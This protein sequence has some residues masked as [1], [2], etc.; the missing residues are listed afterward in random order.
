MSINPEIVSIACKVKP[1]QATLVPEKRKELTTEGGLDVV[2]NYKEIKKVILKLQKNKIPVSLF[3]DP[4]KKQIDAA[5]KIGVTRI[6]LHTGKFAN[7]KTEDEQSIYLE[8]LKLSADYAKEIGLHVFA[9]HGLDYHN[10]TKITS[11]SVIEELN[12]GYSIICRAVFVGLTQAVR[13]MK[14]LIN[15]IHSGSVFYSGSVLR[16]GSG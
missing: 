4:D 9:G 5:K 8:E 13:E 15:L 16:S 2:S 10:V 6:E 11:I 3:I 12:I 1:Y 14:D 7:A